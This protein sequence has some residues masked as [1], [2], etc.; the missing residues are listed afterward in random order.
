MCKKKKKKKSWYNLLGLELAL[1]IMLNSPGGGS[2]LK[3]S[4]GQ[5]SHDPNSLND[6][7]HWAW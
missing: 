2:G 1:N 5:E 7:Y 6:A 3:E 4:G